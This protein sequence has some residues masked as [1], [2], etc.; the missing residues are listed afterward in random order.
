MKLLVYVVKYY[1]CCENEN[2][3]SCGGP[4]VDSVWFDKEKAEAYAAQHY[5]YIVDEHE[6]KDCENLERVT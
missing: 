3:C 1:N 2:C 6:V 4:I 5:H